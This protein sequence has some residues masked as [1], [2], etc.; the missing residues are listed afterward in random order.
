MDQLTWLGLDA[1]TVEKLRPYLTLLPDR[2]PVNINTAPKE[3][4]ASVI[5]GLDLARASR[6][7]QARQ[8]NAFKAVD[9]V[10]TLLAMS[11]L[12]VS[13][14]GVTSDFFEVR[15]R[16]RYEDNVIEQRHLVQR[17]GDDVV[18]RSRARF[19][20]VDR[21]NEGSPPP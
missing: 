20:G 21:L 12:N 17:T 19:A 2:T 6:L 5:D 14:V 4:I 7:V 16:L 10:P 18:V 8:R 15:G 1:G 11:A 3:V 9:E 13:R